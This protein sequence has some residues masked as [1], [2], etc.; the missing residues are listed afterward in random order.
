[1]DDS[2]GGR[3]QNN[4][5]SHDTGGDHKKGTFLNEAVHISLYRLLGSVV[6]IGA[7][8]QGDQA[9]DQIGNGRVFPDSCHYFGVCCGKDGAEK[10]AHCV[11]KAQAVCKAKDCPSQ[12]TAHRTD[13]FA[14]AVDIPHIQKAGAGNSG[15]GTGDQGRMGNG[16]RDR[17]NSPEILGRIP[18]SSG[19]QC[20]S[21]S[22]QDG[23]DHTV[24]AGVDI[25]KDDV[26]E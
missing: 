9:N 6:N 26:P 15:S 4:A 23:C 18:G 3:N 12:K 7:G 20:H 1:M 19:A 22:D 13:P 10:A 21:R 24:D 5:H 8:N 14:L 17:R 16:G 25:T 11:A 2:C